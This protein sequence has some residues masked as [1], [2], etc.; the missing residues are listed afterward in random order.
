MASAATITVNQIQTIDTVHMRLPSTLAIQPNSS[1]NV[2]KRQKFKLEPIKI[3]EPSNKKL[4]LPESQ[5]L[6]C[7]LEE[8]IKKVGM[9]DLITYII[10]NALQI[11]KLIWT[12]RPR[13]TFI[14]RV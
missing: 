1:Q 13:N 12:S 11:Q 3:L 6:M 8:L 7:I 5:R 2:A 4:N 10:Y 14:P 9:L